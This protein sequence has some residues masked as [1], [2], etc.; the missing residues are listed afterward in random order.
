LFGERRAVGEFSNR[1]FDH[2]SETRR[3]SLQFKEVTE[4]VLPSYGEDRFWMKLHSFDA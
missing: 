1:V 3:A 4:E 2:G